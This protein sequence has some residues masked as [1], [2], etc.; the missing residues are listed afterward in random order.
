MSFFLKVG[1]GD[2]FI[3]GPFLKLGGCLRTCFIRL[4][5][6]C[7]LCW[8]KKKEIHSK[9]YIFTQ[10]VLKVKLNQNQKLNKYKNSNEERQITL[11]PELRTSFKSFD[12][13]NNI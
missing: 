1:F 4:L 8:F 7:G 13:K 2:F 11:D 6:F 3:G 5:V 12:E 10:C 9:Y